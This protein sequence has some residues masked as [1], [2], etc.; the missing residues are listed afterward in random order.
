MEGQKY[1]KCGG[2][3]CAARFPVPAKDDRARKLKIC[4]LK[5]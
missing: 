2:G 4:Q 3:Q 1:H 5:I